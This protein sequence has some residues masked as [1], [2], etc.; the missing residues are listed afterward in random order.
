MSKFRVAAVA[1]MLVLSGGAVAQEL[2][3]SERG[4]EYAERMCAECHAVRAGQTQSPDLKATAFQTVASTPSMTGTAL[5]VW[6]RTP[7]PTMP[8]LIIP[9][10]DQYDLIAYITSL[11]E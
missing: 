6:L 10:E 4:L 1:A 3:N 2:G 11:K 9:E 7:H 5:Y 8:N